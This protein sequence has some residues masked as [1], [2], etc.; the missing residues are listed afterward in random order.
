MPAESRPA[1]CP[2]EPSAIRMVIRKAEW[3]LAEAGG[4]HL[5]WEE[6]I[7]PVNGS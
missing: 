1:A 6:A 3:E 2:T 7:S 4:D 5:L